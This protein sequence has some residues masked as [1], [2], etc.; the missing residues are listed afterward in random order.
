MEKSKPPGFSI[1]EKKQPRT[2]G[3]TGGGAFSDTS[4]TD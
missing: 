4:V 2:P 3:S 1:E